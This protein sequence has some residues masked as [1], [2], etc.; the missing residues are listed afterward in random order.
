MK[1]EEIIKVYEAGPE[2]VVELAE[3]LL[4]RIKQLEDQI[5]KNSRNSSKPPSTD[6]FKKPQPKSLR[7]KGK[8][9][10]GGQ[11][12]HP[13]HT[14]FMTEQ[15]DHV[16]V[17]RV[18]TCSCGHDLE[19]VK[20]TRQERRQVWDVPPLKMEVTEHRAEAKIC[21]FCG[22]LNKAEFP[23]NVTAPVQYGTGVKSLMTYLSQY[24]LLP[25]D[26]IREFFQDLFEQDISQAT[27]IQA[28]ESLYE[29]LKNFEA[30]IVERIKTSDVVHFDETGV[31]VE[32]KLHWLHVASTS[33][34]TYYSVQ[35]QRGQVGI[36][37]AGILPSF[38]GR[39][40]HDAWNPYWRYACLHALCNAHL[41]RELTF[42]FEQEG[43]TWADAMGKLLLEIKKRVEEKKDSAVA[44]EME[45]VTEFI[46]RYDR[47]IDM[48]LAEDARLNPQQPKTAKKRGRSKQS[49]AK[50]LLDRLVEHHKEVLAFMCDFRVPF[51]NNLAE[52]DIRMMKVQQKISGT[53]R[54]EE[55]AKTFCRIRGMISTLKKQSLSVIEGIRAA[56]EG[57]PILYPFDL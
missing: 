53:F 38:S 33:E 3:S 24:Q 2:A 50:N 45:E 22:N 23:S 1:R 9:P 8:R 21:P 13:G 43:Q 17:H 26:R 48:G 44:L 37:A 46:K 12:G 57:K 18:V 11:N 47:I 52:R 34:Y 27:C 31:R 41:L 39:A 35:K 16:I 49:K 30:D 36:D 28:N 42:I 7:E 54:S 6:G 40:V 56:F 20:S 5:N 29:R 51:D 19:Q 32:G 55:G 4:E 14:L 10:V 15:P 25:Y